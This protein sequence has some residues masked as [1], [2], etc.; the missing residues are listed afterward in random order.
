[1]LTTPTTP[2][3][4]E[5]EPCEGTGRREWSEDHFSPVSGHHLRGGHVDCGDCGGTGFVAPMCTACSDRR[6]TQGADD[7]WNAPD[8]YLCAECAAEQAV[9]KEAA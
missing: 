8:P 4:A 1:M 6:A 9:A 3:T 2:L 7:R 5:C